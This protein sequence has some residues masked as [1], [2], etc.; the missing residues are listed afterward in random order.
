VL[1]NSHLLP[2]CTGVNSFCVRKTYRTPSGYSTLIRR[3]AEFR[4]AVQAHI[5]KH[6]AQLRDDVTLDSRAREVRGKP[7]LD[8]DDEV[9]RRAFE[10]VRA[11]YSGMAPLDLKKRSS[12]P[13]AAP[14]RPAGGPPLERER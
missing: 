14:Q 13:M 2:S 11:A 3:R 1:S 4:A 9:R 8:V 5:N 6:G 10:A 12:P 7:P